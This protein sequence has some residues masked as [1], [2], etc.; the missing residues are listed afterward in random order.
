[1]T[2]K[3]PREI[4]N[5]LG[6]FTYTHTS[7][8]VFHIGIKSISFNSYCTFLM[9]SPE[10]ALCDIIWTTKSLPITSLK[11]MIYFLEEDIRFEMDFFANAN[12]EIFEECI[13]FGNKKKELNYFIKLCKMYAQ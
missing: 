9:A 8:A 5:E 4:N 1:M 6:R 12:I 3:R 7:E 13:E 2:L 10:K 11:D